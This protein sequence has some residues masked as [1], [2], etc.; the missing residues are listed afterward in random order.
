MATVEDRWVEYKH[1]P[2]KDLLRICVGLNIDIIWKA[3]KDDIIRT[4]IEVQDKLANND[5]TMNPYSATTVTQFISGYECLEPLPTANPR[6]QRAERYGLFLKNDLIKRCRDIKVVMGWRSGRN[7]IIEA[8]LNAEDQAGPSMMRVRRITSTAEPTNLDEDQPMARQHMYYKEKSRNFLKRRCRVFSISRSK[9]RPTS[10]LARN[11]MEVEGKASG[12]QKIKHIYIPPGPYAPLMP[13]TSLIPTTQRTIPTTQAPTRN[14]VLGPDPHQHPNHA[15][16][17]V[18]YPEPTHNLIAG[19]GL[20]IVATTQLNP[21][22]ERYRNHTQ[23]PMELSYEPLYR[24]ARMNEAA[25]IYNEMTLT[26]LQDIVRARGYT[27]GIEQASDTKLECI[28]ILLEDDRKQG[29]LPTAPDPVYS[30]EP[31]QLAYSNPDPSIFIR[32]PTLMQ[33]EV[34]SILLT[35]QPDPEEFQL[36]REEFY[37]EF[38]LAEIEK[39]V[40]ARRVMYAPTVRRQLVRSDMRIFERVRRKRAGLPPRGN[41]IQ[42]TQGGTVTTTTTAT[43]TATTV[44]TPPVAKAATA[45]ET[46]ATSPPVAATTTGTETTVTSPPVAKTTT[47]TETIVPNPPRAKSVTFAPV[48]DGS[49]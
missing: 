32:I 33:V 34:F 28:D 42:Q 25:E 47:A 40:L 9:R 4:I 43:A 14:I 39:E 36:S 13:S 35:S 21:I 41:E 22:Y 16:I 1:M 44:T 26:Q 48:F 29:F 10:Q 12:M 45:T 49:R 18:I 3:W 2:K 23:M 27:R 19:T 15:D 6:S 11:I 7:D 37:E 46:T 38:T 24:T 17:T 31:G 5:R 30:L 20:P 8:I